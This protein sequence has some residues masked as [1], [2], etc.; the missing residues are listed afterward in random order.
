MN[1]AAL[2]RYKVY[3]RTFGEAPGQAVLAELAAYC[4]ADKTTMRSREDGAVDPLASAVLEGRRQ[5]WLF[6]QRALV[7]PQDTDEKEEADGRLE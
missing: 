2:E 7:E 3:L 6:L 4:C 1:A 5:V